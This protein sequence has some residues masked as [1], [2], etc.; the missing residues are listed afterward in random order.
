MPRG[1]QGQGFDRTPYQRVAVT[2]A[3][4]RVRATDPAVYPRNSTKRCFLLMPATGL[5][6]EVTDPDEPVGVPVPPA[7][8]LAAV[9]M[10]NLREI[11][12]G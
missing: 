8:L 3:T 12:N 11:Y 9:V 2:A 7:R 5:C 10:D 1:R 4:E 6:V